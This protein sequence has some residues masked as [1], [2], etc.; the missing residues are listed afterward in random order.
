MPPI[1]GHLARLRRTAASTSELPQHL[2]IL[3][4]RARRAHFLAQVRMVVKPR[5]TD[6][7]HVPL[8]DARARTRKGFYGI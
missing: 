5:E 2:A 6:G 8:H 4:Q 7:E 1:P 3:C